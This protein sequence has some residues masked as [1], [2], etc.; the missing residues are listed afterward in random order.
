MINRSLPSSFMPFYDNAVLSLRCHIYLFYLYWLIAKPS[1]L[2]SPRNFQPQE[3]WDWIDAQWHPLWSTNRDVERK[4]Q[5]PVLPPLPLCGNE[6]SEHWFLVKTIDNWPNQ[7]QGIVKCLF[8][9]IYGH[10]L[11]GSDL[12]LS[13]WNLH[14]LFNFTDGIFYVHSE[15]TL[16][17]NNAWDIQNFWAWEY[18][19]WVVFIC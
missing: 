16:E 7:N 17:G 1:I 9:Q 11:S 8:S 15:V 3:N 6:C 13:L 10:F 19:R 4:V 18:L 12:A 2:N 5:I 14:L